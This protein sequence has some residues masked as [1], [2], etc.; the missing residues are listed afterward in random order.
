[1]EVIIK[2]WYWI[3]LIGFD[4]TLE[5]LGVTEFLSRVSPEITGLSTFLYSSEFINSYDGLEIVIL[6]IKTASVL[7]VVLGKCIV[8]QTGFKN[9]FGIW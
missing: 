4:N 2:R 6:F 9:T 3:E 5:D 1:M 8:C 7:R